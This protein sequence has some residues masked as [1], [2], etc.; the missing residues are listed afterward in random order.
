MANQIVFDAIEF[1]T[2][3]H[4]GQYRK[5]TRVPY[6]VHPLR[7][8][9]MLIECEAP[10]QVVVAGVLH[11][12]VEDTPVTREQIAARFG[13]PVAELVLEASE[14]D[15]GANWEV[16]KQCTIDHLDAVSNEA[17]LVICA[18]KLDNVGSMQR[19]EHR[20]GPDFWDRF[21]RP[22]AKQGW[23]Y[24]SVAAAIRARAE[25]EPLLGL[26]DRLVR[27]VEVLFAP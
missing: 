13:K 10:T 3:A 16:R 7:V 1:A 19:G 5:G 21:H 11:D 25:R 17:L 6:I 8:G 9:Q 15:R 24:Q 20:E 22:K 4:S 26:A 2:R 14:P 18:D 12:T 23:Y 27:A